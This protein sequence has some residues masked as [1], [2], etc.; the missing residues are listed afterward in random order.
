LWPALTFAVQNSS[1]GPQSSAKR[2]WFA[3]AISEL[4]EANPDSD[5]DYVEEFLLQV[6]NDEFD[7]N[8]EDGS[9]EEIAIKIVG[10]RKSTL[11]GDFTKIDELLTRWQEKQGRGED[12]VNFHHVETEEEDGTESDSDEMEEDESDDEV[13]MGEPAKP[14]KEKVVPRTDEDGFTEVIGRRK[15]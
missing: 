11:A 5:V 3:G 13:E 4:L 6:M 7:L 2:D 8:V 9:A 1:G 10:F 12:V 15:R 14:L